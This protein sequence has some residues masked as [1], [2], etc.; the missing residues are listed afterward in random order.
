MKTVILTAL[1]CTVLYFTVLYCTGAGVWS[2]VLALVT[3]PLLPNR[4]L[5]SPRSLGP[6]SGLMLLATA[7]L[8]VRCDWSRHNTAHL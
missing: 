3:L 4:L 6:V 5:L 1:Y 8:Q 7:L 2:V